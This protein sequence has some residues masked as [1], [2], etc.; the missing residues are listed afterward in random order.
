MPFE[1][2][3]LLNLHQK[4]VVYLP[5]LDAVEGFSLV[6]FITIGLMWI[7]V[8]LLTV[9]AALAI[10][11]IIGLFENALI[12]FYHCFGGHPFSWR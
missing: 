10:A 8:S 9:A 3:I 7:T 4:L 5:L 6:L 12:D 1:L 11:F 2:V